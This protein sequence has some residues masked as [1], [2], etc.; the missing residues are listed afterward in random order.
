M[1]R[2]RIAERAR[3]RMRGAPVEHRARA[4]RFSFI[5]RV[6]FPPFREYLPVRI[7]FFRFRSFALE[8]GKTSKNRII[9]SLF[10]L[11]Y[12]DKTVKGAKK[13]EE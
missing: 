13:K 5:I 12:G 11:V 2:K 8:K 1:E 3:P 10:L 4:L 7:F 9:L 6:E